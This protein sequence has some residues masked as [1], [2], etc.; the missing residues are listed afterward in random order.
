MEFFNNS[1]WMSGYPLGIVLAVV[2]V[3]YNKF[4]SG[5]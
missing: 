5:K 1:F 4:S 2:L 3:L